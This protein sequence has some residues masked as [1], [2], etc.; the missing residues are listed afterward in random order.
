[1]MRPSPFGSGFRTCRAVPSLHHDDIHNTV[2]FQEYRCFDAV[3]LAELVRTHEIH[4]RE[5][6]ALAL[7]AIADVNP[8][9]NAII[10]TFDT[11]LSLADSAG[12]LYGV[13]FLVKDLVLHRA[14]GLLEM[15]S[16]MARG[17]VT[18]ADTEL[19]L[20]LRRAGLNVVGR[21]TTPELGH[22]CTTESVLTGPTRNPWD[23][24]RMAGG[25]S[26]GSAAAVA[27]G[28]VP[29]AHANDG[30]GSI[31]IPAA[32]CGLFGLKPSRGRISLGPDAGEALFGMGIEHAV[33]R[34]VRDSATLLDCT[35][36]AG[37]GDP[38]VIAGPT[39]PFSEAVRRPPP[40]LRIAMA[41]RAW[42]GRRSNSR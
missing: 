18:P 38:Y 41:T 39:M 32:C 34:S 8:R 27:A 6:A 20:R 7:A 3:G 31:R 14:G 10:Q 29:A 26:G 25:S 35:H 16:R 17:M 28:I 22:G 13:P 12:P 19:L 2:N 24:A 21:T 5:L 23:L 33:T 11:E 40:P 9:I 37:V 15:G 30:A 1:M 42:S 4:P 36:G